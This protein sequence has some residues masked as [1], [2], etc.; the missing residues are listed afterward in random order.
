MRRWRVVRLLCLISFS[1]L[2]LTSSTA[3]GQEI[4]LDVISQIES[5]NNP[6]AYNSRTGATG[7]FQITL[8]V[9]QEY[10]RYLRRQKRM[11]KIL[12]KI[13]RKQSLKRGWLQDREL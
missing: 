3:Y 11:G 12:Q 10:I 7:L 1:F 4:N 2:L 13:K 9:S 8:P 6:D 5:S